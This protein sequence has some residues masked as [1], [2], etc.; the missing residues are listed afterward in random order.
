MDRN[1]N[2]HHTRNRRRDHED[3]SPSGFLPECLSQVPELGT[4]FVVDYR[5]CVGDPI[6]ASARAAAVRAAARS[7]ATAVVIAAASPCVRPFPRTQ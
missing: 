4:E 5:V 7:S 6:A 1:N 2:F 3:V